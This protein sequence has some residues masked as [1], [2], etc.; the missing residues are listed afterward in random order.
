MNP[1]ERGDLFATDGERSA[2]RLGFQPSGEPSQRLDW[3]LTEAG[4]SALAVGAR[5]ATNAVLNSTRD[6]ASSTLP[7]AY[8]RLMA[9][10]LRRTASD[11]FT[12]LTDDHRQAGPSIGN[13]FNQFPIL[14][15]PLA[16]PT[17][18][19]TVSRPR[20]VVRAES[21]GWLAFCAIELP[22]S[23]LTCGC[24]RAGRSELYLTALRL[25]PMRIPDLRRVD[26][27]HV[28]IRLDVTRAVDEDFPRPDGL[29]SECGG[30][31]ARRSR[32][33]RTWA[34]SSPVTNRAWS[35]SGTSMTRRI[36]GAMPRPARITASSWV[37]PPSRT[38][39]LPVV[40][41]GTI[42][43]VAGKPLRTRGL[44][45]IKPAS[46]IGASRPTPRASMPSRWRPLI[47]A[48]CLS[49]RANCPPTASASNRAV[50]PSQRLDW[51]LT[52]A[53]TAGSSRREEAP[54]AS[55][56]TPKSGGQT[57]NQSLLTSARYESWA[58]HRRR[59]RP[60]G[61]AG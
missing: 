23:G 22:P 45:S 4:A 49:R 10:K 52:E 59:H 58:W 39:A 2:Y 27:N 42:T 34:A 35:G 26:S 29:R 32:S 18:S 13:S 61:R 5:R 19:R 40:V 54:P 24:R 6:A 60:H 3:V 21:D 25:Q 36:R 33:A 14:F 53:G 46:R 8:C 55:P 30:A 16:R 43:D 1:S 44:K 11:A 38:A 17:V 47:A 51:V 31:H 57:P 37:R 15:R 48:T 7:L 20:N 41:S 9:P 12:N 50:K 56:D 28:A